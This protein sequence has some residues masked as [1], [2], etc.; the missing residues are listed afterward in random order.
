M[1][2]PVNGSLWYVVHAKSQKEL[3]AASMLEDQRKLT[4]FLPEVLQKY[5]DKMKLRPFFPGYLFVKA[6][7]EVVEY[8]AI[9]STPGVIRLVAFDQRPLP[10][11]SDIIEGIRSEV[12]RLN[13]EGGLPAI[14]YQ[15]GESVRLIEGP[16]KGL[17]A[18]F[19]K[20]LR[21]SERVLVLLKFLGQENEVELDLSEIE[22]A[23]VVRRKRRTRGKGRKIHYKDDKKTGKPRDR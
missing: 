14:S 3:L 23:S 21:P 4:D 11:N 10:L 19:V 18:V 9:N 1:S 7:L 8:T 15:P 16:L 20:H 17:Q 12:E 13:S 22:R 6:D 2:D 5:R